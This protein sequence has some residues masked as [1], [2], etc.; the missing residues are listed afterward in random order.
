MQLCSIS[1][2]GQYSKLEEFDGKLSQLYLKAP[3]LFF[4]WPE[5]TDED[6]KKFAWKR[7]SAE[8]FTTKVSIAPLQWNCFLQSI[9]LLSLHQIWSIMSDA[10][11]SLIQSI[12]L[13][14]EGEIDLK[15]AEE[16]TQSIDSVENRVTTWMN[17]NN[18]SSEASVNNSSQSGANDSSDDNEDDDGDDG[19]PTEKLMIAIDALNSW[20]KNVIDVVEEY[21]EDESDADEEEE[22]DDPAQPVSLGSNRSKVPGSKLKSLAD[23]ANAID[24]RVY[25]LADLQKTVDA[26]QENYHFACKRA[27]EIIF[28]TESVSESDTLSQ[29]EDRIRSLDLTDDE[30]APSAEQKQLIESIQT[31]ISR[32]HLVFSK[33]QTLLTQLEEISP[34]TT[35]LEPEFAQINRWIEESVHFLNE[36]IAVGCLDTLSDQLT[37]CERLKDYMECSVEKSFQT[38]LS[39]AKEAVRILLGKSNFEVPVIAHIQETWTNLGQRTLTKLDRLRLAQE[40]TQKLIKSLDEHQTWLRDFE[41]DILREGGQEVKGEELKT[42]YDELKEDLTVENFNWSSAIPGKMQLNRLQAKRSEYLRATLEPPDSLLS[43]MQSFY[44]NGSQSNHVFDKLKKRAKT[45]LVRAFDALENKLKTKIAK[46]EAHLDSLTRLMGMTGK[47]KSLQNHL[48]LLLTDVQKKQRKSMENTEDAS[49]AL[50]DLEQIL[51]ESIS[52]SRQSRLAQIQSFL[53]DN[54]NLVQFLLDSKQEA[55]VEDL[56][57]Q[58]E[59]IL[60][61]D[62]KLRTQAEAEVELIEKFSSNWKDFDNRIC[63]L[64][65]WLQELNPEKVSTTSLS[66]KQQELRLIEKLFSDKFASFRTAKSRFET[67]IELV[68][69]IINEF[70]RDQLVQSELPS[71][72]N[73]FEE[74]LSQMEQFLADLGL[75]INEL[76]VTFDEESFLAHSQEQEYG[77]EFELQLIPAMLQKVIDTVCVSYESQLREFQQQLTTMK[78]SDHLKS[79][80][81]EERLSKLSQTHQALVNSLQLRRLLL[82]E[83]ISLCGQINNKLMDLE[84]ECSKVFAVEKGTVSEAELTD[85]KLSS[86]KILADVCQLKE[87]LD[88]H[89]IRHSEILIGIE[90]VGARYDEIITEIAEQ[91]VDVEEDEE[92]EENQNADIQ[93]NN[94]V[95]PE[96]IR[97]RGAN[98][99]VSASVTVTAAHLSTITEEVSSAVEVSTSVETTAKPSQ[100]VIPKIKVVSPDNQERPTTILPLITKPVDIETVKEQIRTCPYSVKPYIAQLQSLERKIN[101]ICCSTGLTSSISKGPKLSIS[102]VED[103]LHRLNKCLNEVRVPYELALCAASVSGLIVASPEKLKPET[104]PKN[105]DSQEFA[106]CGSLKWDKHSSEVVQSLTNLQSEFGHSWNRFLSL[107][108]HWWLVRDA[109]LQFNAEIRKLA[110][111]FE[112]V[113]LQLTNGRITTVTVDDAQPYGCFTF[114]VDDLNYANVVRTQLLLIAQL[115]SHVS[116]WAKIQVLYKRLVVCFTPDDEMSPSSSF[117]DRKALLDARSRIEHE[118]NQ[119]SLRWNAIVRE[120][121]WRRECLL[122]LSSGL[123]TVNISGYPYKKGTDSD[124]DKVLDDFVRYESPS[125]NEL[126]ASSNSWFQLEQLTQWQKETEKGLEAIR[127]EF[128]ISDIESSVQLSIKVREYQQDLSRQLLN[129]M[130]ITQE[131]FTNLKV[132]QQVSLGHEQTL[133]AE[134]RSTIDVSFQKVRF[135]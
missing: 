74:Q 79:A 121:A 72:D 48:K 3:L 97:Y 20:L 117:E 104:S 65:K 21:D 105:E 9:D 61:D 39:T 107:H 76:E 63:T 73:A 24:N 46:T 88:I 109:T 131:P 108:R 35:L 84:E 132:I 82:E 120:L 19:D 92:E 50:K 70:T 78:A 58:L 38:I 80:V 27:A 12:E 111:W 36:A 51:T 28:G 100:L 126:A 122:A 5:K 113:E 85:M 102:L 57:S 2:Q 98:N 16:N 18:S 93:G 10:G 64:Q 119:V 42:L 95:V 59:K 91:Y 40:L 41:I 77:P 66:S 7:L 49:I 94:S 34:S 52:G 124:F 53:V 128:T 90:E 130:V 33:F 106:E 44:S 13:A 54:S 37:E 125:K 96:Q 71:D 81:L 134:Q 67:R 25:V 60:T 83:L 103:E 69:Q 115:R 129:W 101:S 123:L 8:K 68:Q 75:V 112:N 4:C 17:K 89:C 30:T 133:N 11:H 135:G 15:D 86:H 1:I 116:I 47:E 118:F 62:S 29:I 56:Q 127:S 114:D 32:W 14:I 22:E 6:A 26:E 23:L 87:R 110:D 55:I 43:Q 31:L 99:M 45:E